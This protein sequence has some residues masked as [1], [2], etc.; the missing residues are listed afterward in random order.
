MTCFQK[1]TK[2]SFRNDTARLIGL[3]ELRVPEHCSRLRQQ[4]EP[5]RLGG[6]VIPISPFC[7]SESAFISSALPCFYYIIL[8][9]MRE[10]FR[11][12]RHTCDLR[13]VIKKITRLLVY[14]PFCTEMKLSSLYSYLAR[15]RCSIYIHIGRQ[16]LRKIVL[17]AVH[18]DFRSSL[19]SRTHSVSRVADCYS[20]S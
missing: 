3:F 1:I 12:L 9:C 5:W 20:S 19:N 10:L 15:P 13:Q 14:L 2:L 18:V 11:T 6:N 17:S 7:S 8:W 4:R 16:H